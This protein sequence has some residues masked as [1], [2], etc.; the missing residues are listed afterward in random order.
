MVQCDS[1]HAVLTTHSK[2]LLVLPCRAV[3]VQVGGR[4]RC[5]PYGFNQK[6]EQ[7]VVFD[8]GAVL[9]T[10]RDR[11]PRLQDQSSQK[12]ELSAV[13]QRGQNEEFASPEPLRCPGA[14]TG[15]SLPLPAKGVPKNQ[16][17]HGPDVGRLSRDAP[18]NHSAN[19]FAGAAVAPQTT[20]R[21]YLLQSQ[22]LH[23]RY[24]C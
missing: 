20:F 11:H 14:P 7:V 15:S 4:D 22:I 17:G 16:M 5:D 13:G 24:S 21:R 8:G 6:V 2:W 19:T 3:T 23:V 1:F 10:V 12:M 18:P 9:R